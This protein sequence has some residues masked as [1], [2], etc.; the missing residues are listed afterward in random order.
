MIENLLKPLAKS[1]LV[2][3]GSK[4]AAAVTDAAFKKKIFG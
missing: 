2:T 3:L 4:A 1:A